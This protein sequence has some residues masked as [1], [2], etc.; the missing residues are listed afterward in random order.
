MTDRVPKS[1]IPVAGRPF[2]F[3]QL[4]LLKHQGVERIVLCLGHLGG[5]IRSAVGDGSAFGLDIAYSHDGETLLG[6]GGAVRG[7]LP[8]LGERFLVLN[9]DSYLPCSLAAI[10][11]SFAASR[12]PAL[13]TVL[14][15]DD[16]WQA[17]NVLLRD[18]ELIEYDKRQRRPGMAHI[19]FGLLGLS[20]AIFSRYPSSQPLDLADVC[21]DLS[22]SREMAAYEVTERFYEIGSREGLRDTEALLTGSAH[23]GEAPPPGSAQPAEAPPRGFAYPTEAPPPGFAYPT[24]ARVP[25]G[26]AA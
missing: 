14:R 13:M 26:D 6:T 10:A 20:A 12:S 19:D 7:A 25:H 8:L 4:D 11:R 5:Q 18:G 24:D 16:R 3:H 23:P 2:A 9:G 22:R 17:S 1:L 21:R 15:N